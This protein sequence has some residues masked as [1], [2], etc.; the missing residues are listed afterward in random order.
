M[1]IQVDQIPD[2]YAEYV[3]DIL[4]QLGISSCVDL[5]YMSL[6]CGWEIAFQKL[7]FQR[8]AVLLEVYRDNRLLSNLIHG[9]GWEK[10]PEHQTHDKQG[11]PTFGTVNI[12]PNQLYK[13]LL[14]KYAE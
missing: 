1:D 14:N 11:I 7:F 4:A 13:D 3:T 6:R 5:R 10:P 12:F 2:E 9:L 8:K